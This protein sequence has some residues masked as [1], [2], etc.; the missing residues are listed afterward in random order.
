MSNKCEKEIKEKRRRRRRKRRRR[1]RKKKEMNGRVRERKNDNTT[2]FPSELPPTPHPLQ[3]YRRAA[4]C[5][6]ALVDVCYALAKVELGH[7]QKRTM[8]EQMEDATRVI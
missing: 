4:T 5:L 8:S 3:P 7:T 6:L 2:Q 1:R